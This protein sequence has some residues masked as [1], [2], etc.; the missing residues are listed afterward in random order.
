MKIKFYIK[1]EYEI[2]VPDENSTC[3][4]DAVDYVS[5]NWMDI[6]ENGDAKLVSESFDDVEA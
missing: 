5:Y 6:V 4:S 1:S 2:E 3:Y